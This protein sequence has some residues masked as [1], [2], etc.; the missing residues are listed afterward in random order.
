MKRSYFAG[1]SLLLHKRSFSCHCIHLFQVKKLWSPRLQRVHAVPYQWRGGARV[2]RECEQAVAKIDAA[3]HAPRRKHT[4]A[5]GPGRLCKIPK[6]ECR[7]RRSIWKRNK[8]NPGSCRD[9]QI[10][11]IA[12]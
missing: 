10:R 3:G 11:A 5:K 7:L 2:G 12:S 9:S 8:K 6:V 4:Q 1:I